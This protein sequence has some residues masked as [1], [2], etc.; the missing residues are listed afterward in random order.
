MAIAP[1][2]LPF[3]PRPIPTELFSSWLLRVAAANLALRELL[4]GLEARYGRMLTDAPID[5]SLPQAAIVAANPPTCG[6]TGLCSLAVLPRG[7]R[8]YSGPGSSSAGSLSQPCAASP[9][10]ER[11]STLSTLQL[12]PGSLRLM[13]VVYCRAARNSRALGWE[14]RWSDWLCSSS[15]ASLGRLSGLPRA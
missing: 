6:A 12:A 5:Y 9:F 2:Q 13:S 11:R 15:N 4:A 3:A 14:H 7:P 8:R 1:K 10:S